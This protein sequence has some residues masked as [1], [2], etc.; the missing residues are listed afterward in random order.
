MLQ[1]IILFITL[2][3]LSASICPADPPTQM[4]PQ[5]ATQEP[6]KTQKDQIDNITPTNKLYNSLFEAI[7]IVLVIAALYIVSRKMRERF[8]GG[9]VVRKK[10]TDKLQIEDRVSLG[11]RF[12]I[13]VVGYRGQQAMVGLSPNGMYHIK[14]LDPTSTTETTISTESLDSAELQKSGA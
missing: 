2:F 6:A 8:I 10:N 14:D 4:T 13:V 1:K 12:H 9:K 11:G 7:A 5:P 3:S